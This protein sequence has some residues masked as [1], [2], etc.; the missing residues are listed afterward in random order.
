MA[1][2][3]DSDVEKRSFDFFLNRAGQ[4][5]GGFFN[6][7]F[8]TREI[9]QAAISSPSIRHL[10]VALGAVYEQF[11]CR[12]PD[13]QSGID[14]MRFALQQ[15]NHSIRH[16]SNLASSTRQSAED[17]CCIIAAS[18]LFAT[19]AS[20]QGYIAQAINHIRSGMRVLRSLES[21][22]VSGLS[23]PV[24]VIRLRSLLTNLYAQARTM[25]N[26]EALTKWHGQ[27]PLVSNF[28]PVACFPSLS[29]AHD[30]VEA[31]YNN[32]LAFLQT[33]ELFP[34]VTSEQKEK[35]AAQ[36]NMLCCALRSSCDALNVFAARRTNQ[37]DE[38]AIAI[39]RLHQTLL[40][41]RLGVRVVEEDKRESLFDDLEQYLV[42]MLDYCRLILQSCDSNQ[43]E[44]VQ[45]PIF[46]SGLGV[47]MPLHTV[48]ARCR[49]PAVRQEAVDLLLQARRREGLWDS[50]LVEKIVSTTI[51]L[52][53]KGGQEDSGQLSQ[54]SHK[55]PDNDRIREVKIYF[56]GDRSAQIVFIT[57][58][59]W[60]KKQ[61][62]HRRFIEW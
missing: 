46:S 22:E 44:T 3:L 20:L 47:I 30:Y 41:M 54:V 43:S 8:W 19:F 38:K 29:D 40:S 32:T 35:V 26:D 51:K 49:N 18:I 1:L 28:E 27:D 11:E 58:E 55:V 56:E 13:S 45:Q 52:E 16:I 14:D 42:Q 5:L 57:V 25:I 2:W 62:G 36:H 60:R 10:V 21:L 12:E 34:P 37:I 4:R 7:S 50:T 23:F 39:L 31:L 61:S 53:E 6:G 33:T 59:Q 24:P 15:C 17:M 9:L 48:A